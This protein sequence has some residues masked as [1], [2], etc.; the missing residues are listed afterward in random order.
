MSELNLIEAAQGFLDGKVP[1]AVVVGLAM[2]TDREQLPAPM[3]NVVLDLRYEPAGTYRFSYLIGDILHW[4]EKTNHEQNVAH[5]ET[6]AEEIGWS[7]DRIDDLEEEI[8]DVQGERDDKI[9]EW[10]SLTGAVWT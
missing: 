1:S 2:E 10:E 6:L 9:E 8:I 3:S 5:A 4:N 7:A